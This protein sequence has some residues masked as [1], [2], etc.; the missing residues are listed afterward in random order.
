MRRLPLALLALL[1]PAPADAGPPATGK[2]EAAELTRL[3]GA[4]KAVRVQV[5][6]K[7]SE[8]LALEWTLDFQGDRWTMRHPDGTGKGK[9]RLDLA[10][11]PPR[12]DLIGDKG[13]T[14]FCTYR[15]D[16]GRLVL[17]WWPKAKDRQDTLDPEK[18]DPPGVLMVMERPKDAGPVLDARR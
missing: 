6:K 9:V 2:A 15:L 17:C 3:K 5:G 1:L 18:Q 7:A 8:L 14:L 11:R 16:K 10:Q 12:M 13:T 4:W